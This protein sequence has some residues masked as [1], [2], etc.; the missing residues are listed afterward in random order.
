MKNMMKLLMIFSFLISVC[1]AG[2]AAAQVP[3][4]ISMKFIL[5]A[6]GNR[7]VA[8]NLYDNDQINAEFNAALDILARAYTEFTIDRIEFVDLSGLSQW[9]STISD[10]AGRDALRNAAKAAPTTYH[11]RN[12]AI[13]IYINGGND[14]AISDFPPNNNMILMNQ[15]CGN[16][17]SCILHEMGHSLNLAHTHADDGCA[18]TIP[19][20]RYWTRDQISQNSYSC[21]YAN[22]TA[23][24]KDAVDL[25]FNNVMS[26][27]VGEP[28]PR[29]SQCQMNRISSQAYT[30]RN[31]ML[32]KTPVY[33]DKNKFV[34]FQFGTFDLPYT[35]LQGALNAGG[36]D[37]K[38]LVLQQGAYTM[39]QEIIN[40]AVDIVT[41][42]GPS[43]IDRQGARSYVLPVDLENSKHPGVRS[44]VRSTQDEDTMARK[45]AH[46]AENQEKKAAKREE[47]S[48]IRAAA[49]AKQKIH[50]DNAMKSLLEAEKYA[51]GDEQLAI[52]MGLAQRYRFAGDC[53]SAIR[54]LK[55]IADTTDQPGLKQ[56]ALLQIERCGKGKPVTN[57]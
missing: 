51:E 20:N 52:Q 17:P 28:Q 33:V 5:D 10:E 6:N 50:K 11:W 13:N 24:Q 29:L 39:S 3:L 18:D 36:L 44:A 53:S 19:D 48:A 31:W 57:R 34:V 25:V 7:P 37:N 9:Y 26:Y 43:S 41:R 15:G 27:H 8:G 38:V 56:E 54:Y 49:V 23:A 16:N 1:L 46:D 45:I 21:N 30:D 32:S 42:T 14:T 55:K 47:K 35:S 2:D 40:S 12:D 22:C 4:R